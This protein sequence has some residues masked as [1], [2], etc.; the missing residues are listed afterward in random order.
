MSELEEGGGRR[1]HSPSSIVITIDGVRL[2][3]LDDDIHEIVRTYSEMGD[4]IAPAHVAR[5]ALALADLTRVL[6]QIMPA[7]THEYF[8]MVES[9]ARGTLSA[10][11]L[12]EKHEC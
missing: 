3:E 8:V 12:K 7:A 10:L 1:G 6:P 9:L 5:L 2:G 11:L 4:R